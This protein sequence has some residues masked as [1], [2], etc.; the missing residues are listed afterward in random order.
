[1][2]KLL[3]VNVGQ[4]CNPINLPREVGVDYWQFGIAL[5]ESDASFI[6]SLENEFMKNAERINC[7]ILQVWMD[8]RGRQP[9]TWETLVTVLEEIEKSSLAGKI[10][11]YAIKQLCSLHYHLNNYYLAILFLHCIYLLYIGRNCLVVVN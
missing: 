3:H 6:S 4:G 11:R 9:V 7:H 1:M 2:P 5:L 10:R 8:G